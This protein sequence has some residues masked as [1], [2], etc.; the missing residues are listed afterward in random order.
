MEKYFKYIL[1]ILL[2]G[3]IGC[4]SLSEGL[5]DSLAERPLANER[6]RYAGNP[7]ASLRERMNE[8]ASE[9]NRKRNIEQFDQNKPAMTPPRLRPQR[10]PSA[11]IDSTRHNVQWPILYNIEPIRVGPVQ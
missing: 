2:G 1:V 9:I 8:Q 5:D 4:T 11:P 6:V 3:A 10:L 7:N